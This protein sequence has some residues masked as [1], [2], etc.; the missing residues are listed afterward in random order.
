[1]K[2]AIFLIPS[3]PPP[4]LDHPQEFTPAM[5]RFIQACLTKDPSKRPLALD[6]LKVFFLFKIFFF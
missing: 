3:K 5:N 6:L 1:M 2:K 4:T